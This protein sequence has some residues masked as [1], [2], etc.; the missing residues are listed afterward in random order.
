MT[1]GL[2]ES[3]QQKAQVFAAKQV[4]QLLDQGL[5]VH[6]LFVDYW[7]QGTGVD[8]LQASLKAH[9]VALKKAS[10]VTRKTAVATVMGTSRVGTLSQVAG[11]DR[12]ARLAIAVMH[13]ALDI[14]ARPIAEH[15]TAQPTAHAPAEDQPITRN[16]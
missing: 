7:T 15:S 8:A 16:H 5:N 13:Q 12:I 2:L 11:T 6:Q 14:A 9:F 3:A 1:H 4:A 10:I